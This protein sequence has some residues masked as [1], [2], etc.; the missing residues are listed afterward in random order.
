MPG[1]RPSGFHICDILDLNDPKSGQTP[2]NTSDNNNSTDHHN[3]NHHNSSSDNH[4]S[5]GIIGNNG[6]SGTGGTSEHSQSI[7]SVGSIGSSHGSHHGGSGLL[8]TPLT[9]SSYLT[10]SNIS[11]HMINNNETANGSTNIGGAHYHHIF[12]AAS[13]SWSHESNE[14]Y[15]RL[16]LCPH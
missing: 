7:L 12:P 6:D 2:I 8:G 9:S 1:T 3:S 4:Q 16:M 5:S 10:P 13:R 11:N 14:Y 15:G